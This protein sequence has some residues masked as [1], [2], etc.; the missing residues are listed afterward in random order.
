MAYVRASDSIVVGRNSTTAGSAASAPPERGGLAEMLGEVDADA[1][2][3]R[4]IGAGG[5][6]A[7]ATLWAFGVEAPL[8][9][10]LNQVVRLPPALVGSDAT[11]HCRALRE[12]TPTLEGVAAL[13]G[14]Q[15]AVLLVAVPVEAM[16]LDAMRERA[17]NELAELVRLMTW[18]ERR[19]IRRQRRAPRCVC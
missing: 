18:R 4:G 12:L 3:Q 6:D 5:G 19:R 16:W 15:A 14:G 9:G 13:G 7:L 10:H 8:E 2:D 17:L 11:G 1:L